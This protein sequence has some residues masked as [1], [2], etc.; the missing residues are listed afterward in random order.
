MLDKK[1]GTVYKTKRVDIDISYVE[2]VK[3]WL[4]LFTL[5]SMGEN[6]QYFFT[7]GIKIWHLDLN[8]LKKQQLPSLVAVEETRLACKMYFKET[9][10]VLHVGVQL[11]SLLLEDKNIHLAQKNKDSDFL[12]CV[13]SLSFFVTVFLPHLHEFNL[14]NCACSTEKRP[15]P[16]T[17]CWLKWHPTSYTSKP[18][19]D[20][21]VFLSSPR[22][23]SCA[24]QSWSLQTR[25]IDDV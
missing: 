11:G 14:H 3:I 13:S 2:C 24:H 8:L 20:H 21:R 6:S 7:F 19:L 9:A 10:L 4:K 25:I 18:K 1:A 22:K 17:T 5:K 16:H 12:L 15:Q 23:S